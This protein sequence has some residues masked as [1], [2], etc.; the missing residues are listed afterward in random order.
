[1]AFMSIQTLSY[2]HGSHMNFSVGRNLEHFASHAGHCCLPHALQR[3]A[4][5]SANLA[6]QD[7]GRPRQKSQTIVGRKFSRPRTIFLADL[8]R[9]PSQNVRACEVVADNRHIPWRA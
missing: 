4:K 8:C 6:K 9:L 2:T 3:S 5:K 7:P 1:M